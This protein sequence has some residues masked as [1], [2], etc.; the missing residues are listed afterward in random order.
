MD[1]INNED[2]KEVAEQL[3]ARIEN[4]ESAESAIKSKDLKNLMAKIPSLAPEERAEYGKQV[5]QLKQYLLGLGEAQERL[6][7][8][9]L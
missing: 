1:G 9:R 3:R 5:N 6:I 2:I 7:R 4:G 8:G